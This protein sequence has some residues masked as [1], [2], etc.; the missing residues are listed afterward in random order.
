MRNKITLWI[1]NIDAPLVLW[2][3]DENNNTTT[4]V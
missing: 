4:V 2:I 1:E 3:I